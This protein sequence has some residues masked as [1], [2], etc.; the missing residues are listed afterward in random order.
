MNIRKYIFFT[1]AVLAAGL[2]SC[3]VEEQKVTTD[4]VVSD[5]PELTADVVEGQ[6]L[7]R[8]DAR[9]SE[10][11]D[12]AGLTKSG[13]LMPMDRSGI[14]SVDEILDLVD[15]YRIE[16]VFPADSRSEAKAR[17]EGLH[18]W[19]VVSFDEKHPVEKVAADLARLGEVSRVEFNRT[20]KRASHKPAVPLTAV[21]L[22]DAMTRSAQQKFNDS[23]LRYQ[24]N[25]INDGSLNNDEL[26]Q[27][28]FISGADV[29]VEKAWEL[30]TGDP[31]I[32]V[33][34]LDEGVDVDHEDLQASMWVNE[35]EIWA[36]HE[37]NDGN[38]YEGDVH[39]Y[40]FVAKNGVISC[41]SI[42]DTGHG[43]H[44]AG[45]IAAANN[46][47]KGISS[48]AGG[49]ASVP[50]V[51]IMSCQI[52]SGAYAGTV[53]EEVR[54]IK[55]AAD[56]GAVVLQ[57][58]WGYISGAANPYEWTP[59]YSTDEE[60]LQYNVLEKKALDYFVHNAGSPDGVIDGGIV[61]FAGGNEAA[62][63]A[64]YPAAYK[65]YVSVA[66]TAGDFTPAVYTNYGPGTTI[67][68]P[69]GDQ[70][71]Y[72][73][74]QYRYPAFTEDGGKLG[75]GDIGCILSALP[76]HLSP[77]GYGYMEG[78]SMACP[79][80]SGVVALGLSYAAKLRRHF[81]ADEF[82]SL[83]YETATPVDEYMDGTKLYK[84]YVIDLEESSPLMSFSKNEYKGKMGH[85]QVNA[86]ALLKAIEGAGTEMTFPNLFV[87]VD[88]QKTVVP[89]VYMDGTVFTVDVQDPTVATAQ[90]IGGKL[91]VKGLKEGQTEASITGSRTDKFV[92]TVRN[93]AA[94]NGWL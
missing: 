64:S 89:S 86:Y 49:N 6:L 83:L 32:I 92:I 23:Y 79:H 31:S 77:S 74:E 14:L 29:Q 84:K 91:V 72:Y 45:V 15:G 21:Q 24:W 81:T 55:Y 42:Y 59:Q 39:G 46:N 20:L 85:G 11:L 94:G 41:E 52:F 69:G 60:W 18:L 22:A 1:T 4:A 25:L 76:K 5:V 66:A 57:C 73:E 38:G 48:I 9:V 34:V 7:V 88:G 54:A 56:N 37:D 8:F 53:L 10:I 93:G 16:R 71:Y 58:S 67:S 35:G 28:K 43:S 30:T 33:A 62:P 50:G 65:D 19:Y 17:E 44:V 40:N 26:T 78:T 82:K 12:K 47:G 13:P 80:V 70:D 61:V 3:S 87:D 36:S 2:A 27:K 68:A 75:Y 51:R 63:A 90:M